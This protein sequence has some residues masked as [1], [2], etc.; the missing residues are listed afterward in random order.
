MVGKR[1]SDA[2]GCELC[3]KTTASK[4]AAFELKLCT[5]VGN[6]LKLESVESNGADDLQ[7]VIPKPMPSQL[8]KTDVEQNEGSGSW[9]LLER[10]ENYK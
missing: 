4:P 6:V 3:V 1:Q 2:V 5:R 8:M 10:D 7:D 9:D